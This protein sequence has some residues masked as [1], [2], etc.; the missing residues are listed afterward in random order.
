MREPSNNGGSVAE[1]LED[2][3]RTPTNRK[4][5]IIPIVVVLAAIATIVYAYIP[6]NPSVETYE[7]YVVMFEDTKTELNGYMYQ[8]IGEDAVVTLKEEKRLNGVSLDS[9]CMTT[10]TD[11]S[12][13]SS[14]YTTAV[15]EVRPA[16]PDLE[17]DYVALLEENGWTYKP[18]RNDDGT[19][20]NGRFNK[21][22]SFPKKYIDDVHDNQF[23]FKL[24]IIQHND[25]T[26]V[27]IGMSGP[28]VR[29]PEEY[30]DN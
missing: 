16:Q 2:L 6:K 5:R 15:Y 24:T 12:Y 21:S 28:C 20:A 17:N 18:P 27:G 13:G 8:S 4:S 29:L 3:Q 7:A 11:K 1:S 14:M 23:S 19:I 25:Y 22:F 9:P 10:I 30:Q 26:Q